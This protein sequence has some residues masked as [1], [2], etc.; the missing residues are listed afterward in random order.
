MQ[1]IAGKK[2]GVKKQNRLR[3]ICIVLY[4]VAFMFVLY[5]IFVVLHCICIVLYYIVLCVGGS[6]QK[7]V[8]YSS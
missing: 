6:K 1:R 5:C 4:Y 8:L 3:S 2:I 7:G